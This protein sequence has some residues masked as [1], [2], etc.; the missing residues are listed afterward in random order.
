[1]TDWVRSWGDSASASPSDSPGVTK[2][3]CQ[4]REFRD[5]LQK[6]ALQTE[7]TA[8]KVDTLTEAVNHVSTKVQAVESTLS[9]MNASPPKAPPPS[10]PAPDLPAETTGETARQQ[11]FQWD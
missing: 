4:L 11:P 1:M 7:A 10:F 2:I 9:K 6:C 3:L 5:E 8:A